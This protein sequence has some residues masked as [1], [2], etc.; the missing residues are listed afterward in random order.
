MTAIEADVI[1]LV[2]MFTECT[3]TCPVVSAPMAEVVNR[4]TEEE[5]ERIQVLSITLDVEQDSPSVLHNWTE[6]PYAWP[7]LTGSPTALEPVWDAYQV[8]PIPFENETS[9][10]RTWPIPNRR[11]SSTG[12]TGRAPFTMATIGPSRTCSTTSAPSWRRRLADAR[13]SRG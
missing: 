7:H 12:S 10:Q 8:V 2:F 1:I 13:T 9:G 6:R 4:F 11:S 3:E 5:S